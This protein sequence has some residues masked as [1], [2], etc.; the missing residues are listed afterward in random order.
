M[1]TIPEEII[2]KSLQQTAEK[3]EIEFLNSWLKEDK[4]NIAYYFQ[5]EE[6]W[7]SGRLL[8]EATI[9]NGW[10]RLA[11]EIE[12]KSAVN[13]QPVSYKKTFPL[14]L[15]YAAAVCVGVLI[16]SAIWMGALSPLLKTEQ[17]LLVQNIVYNHTG[18]QT[19]FLPDS[20]EVWVNENSK[21]TYPERFEKNRRIVSLEGNAYFDIRKNPQKPFFVEAGS[22]EIEVTG[23]EFFVESALADK[24][25]IT[26]VSGH[27]HLNYKD[28]EGKSRIASLVPGQQA[29]IDRLNGHVKVSKV[30]TEYY[31]T[32]KDGTYRFKDETLE[33]IAGSLAKRFD[34]NI[35]MSD[36][37]K[38]R[39]FTGRVT[40]ADDIRDVL[41]T[42][43]KSYP[44]K[45]Q[46]EGKNIQIGE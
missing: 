21:I 13:P 27:V 6:I 16:A 34:L 40:S 25:L 36:R 9:R 28:K 29:D 8:P 2:L 31:V 11:R 14:W 38:G 32:W 44:I 30:N 7:N 19:V 15:R 33:N 37:I 43:S 23:T 17:E 20:S 12:C 46:I 45:Y 3:E 18:V 10:N 5:L 24:A 41:I 42:F 26:L 35:R 22:V 4:K 1:R 39:R